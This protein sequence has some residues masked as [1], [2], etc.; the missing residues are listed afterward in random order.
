MLE[1]SPM[2]LTRSLPDVDGVVDVEQGQGHEDEPPHPSTMP[3][4]RARM[5]IIRIEV[6]DTGVGLRAADMEE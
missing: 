6:E 1:D 4:R 5:A 3:K 2:P